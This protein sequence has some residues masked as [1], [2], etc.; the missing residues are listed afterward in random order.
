M[1]STGTNNSVGSNYLVVDEMGYG[2]TSTSIYAT[3]ENHKSF[4]VRKAEALKSWLD[5]NCGK[6]SGVKLHNRNE[7]NKFI[8]IRNGSS[9]R[10]QRIVRGWL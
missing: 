10:K 4:N 9:Y 8:S 2:E 1:Y 7:H 6:G 3:Y 5:E